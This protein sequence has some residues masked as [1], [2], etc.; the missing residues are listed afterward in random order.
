MSAGLPG[1]GLG[2][3]FFILSA[4]VAPLLELIESARGNSSRAAWSRVGRQFAIAVSMIAAVDLSLRG[5]FLL[6]GLAGIEAPEAGGVTV[7]PIVQLAIA[8]G[9]LLALIA[10]AKALQ[11]V[12]RMRSRHRPRAR[13][14]NRRTALAAELE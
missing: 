3:L 8:T 5:A 10:G 9:I 13:R 12:A 7:L 6:L 14:P 1:L 2:G 11:L 4:L